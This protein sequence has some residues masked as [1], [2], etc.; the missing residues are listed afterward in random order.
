VL[1]Q[2]DGET[3]AVFADRVAS[4]LDGLFGK[5]VALGT[6]ALSCNERIDP[7]AEAARRQVAGLALGSMAENNSGKL[8]LT[9][10]ERSSGRLRH[11]LSALAQGLHQEWNGAGLEASVEF[12]EAA[13]SAKAAAPF[14]FTARVA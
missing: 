13:R 8:Y 2:I 9:A 4:S 10:S 1:A 11:S 6:V 7:A 14:V 12:G 3:P 5:G